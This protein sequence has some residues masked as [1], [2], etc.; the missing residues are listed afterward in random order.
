V[1]LVWSG[2]P[3]HSNDRSRSIALARLLPLLGAAGVQLVA[4]QRDM[5]AEDAAVL[6]EQAGIVSVGHELETFADT[7]AII[8]ALDLVISVDTS[9]AHLAGAL[10]KP[11]F[12][13]LPFGADFRWLLDRRDSP[14]YPSARLFRQPRLGDWESVVAQ[15]RGE[16]EQWAPVS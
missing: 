4:L 6:H 16:L 2:H 8:S 1:G 3:S 11:V 5:R 7:A 10:A 13:L 9:V 12:V 15:A 14:W